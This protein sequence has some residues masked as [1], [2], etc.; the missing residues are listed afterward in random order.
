MRLELRLALAA[1]TH[2]GH[3]GVVVGESEQLKEQALPNE[4]PGV[5][6]VAGPTASHR[7]SEAAGAALAGRPAEGLRELRAAQGT[8]PRLGR[9]LVAGMPASP[10]RHLDLRLT[11]TTLVADARLVAVEFTELWALVCDLECDDP[12]RTPTPRSSPCSNRSCAKPPKGSGVSD[13]R[14]G[15]V[16]LR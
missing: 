12:A 16:Y 6:S 7:E 1:L 4:Q 10:A 13:L 9:R 8:F 14:N 3:V 2:R 5:R 15:F 11:G